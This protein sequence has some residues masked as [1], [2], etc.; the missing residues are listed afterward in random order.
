LIK[1]YD[2][3]VEIDVLDVDFG[4]FLINFANRL[5]G[6]FL[7]LSWL[8]GL[9]VLLIYLFGLLLFLFHYFDFFVKK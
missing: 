2:F 5:S 8:L 9:E 6:G 4:V 7:R 3:D 1:K